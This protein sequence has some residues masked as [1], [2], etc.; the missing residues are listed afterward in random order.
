MVEV[1][2]GDHEQELVLRLSSAKCLETSVSVRGHR[3]FSR[4]VSY[5]EVTPQRV[6]TE[7]LRVRAR[8]IA[9][10]R[11]LRALVGIQA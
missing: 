3:S 6:L 10:E 11:T 1:R 9:F 7:E 8:D 2:L 5:I 4:V